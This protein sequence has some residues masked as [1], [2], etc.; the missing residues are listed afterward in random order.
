MRITDEKI[1]EIR[2]A[3]DIVEV[4]S[5]YVRLK[6]QGKSFMGLCPFHTEKTPSFS[7]DP[8]RGFYHCFGCRAGG[9]IF[10]FIMQMEKISFPEAVRLLAK[11][12]GIS[13]PEGEDTEKSLETENLFKANALAMAFFEQCMRGTRAGEKSLSY[14]KSRGFE[15]KTL[16]LFHVGYAPNL[17]DGLIQKAQREAMRLSFL[18][19]AGL[20]I[21]GKTKG[22][23]YDRFRARVMFP[24]FNAAG[25]PVGF[26]GR[27]LGTD[28]KQPKY[29]N[30][31]ETPIF[32]KGRHL[33]GLS[34]AKEGIRREDKIVVVEG[35]TDV[36][37]LHQ[38]GMNHAVASSGTAL[39]DEQAQLMMRYSKNV[40][41]VFDG[42]SAGFQ[43][44][45]RGVDIL[46]KKGA[47][48]SVVPLPGGSDPDTAVL[49]RGAAFLRNAVQSAR[50]FVDFQL[51]RMSVTGHLKTPGQK[52]EAAKMLLDIIH[53]LPDRLEQDLMVKEIAG[54]LGVDEHLL[55]QKLQKGVLE[56]AP[57][58]KEKRP[59][60]RE[61]AE[62][63]LIL[64][65]IENSMAWARHIFRWIS[66]ESIAGPEARAVLEWFVMRSGE[67]VPLNGTDLMN[68]FAGDA[69][70]AAYC[71]RLLATGIDDGVDR[72]KLCRGSIYAL[73]REEVQAEVK[74]M[75]EKMRS[76]RTMGMADARN[77]LDMYSNEYMKLRKSLDILRQ[78][79]DSAFKKSVEN[80]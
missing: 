26:G 2:G 12:A 28:K 47:Q 60:A 48:V 45:L 77:T 1:E 56:R 4:I 14:M 66:P 80:E 74:S 73:K 63:D 70:V 68:H 31:P 17:W 10:N 34:L 39:T 57:A 71:A 6:K 38:S 65:L 61:R 69:R 50:T 7:V 37:R 11:Q 41:L 22:A 79:L 76:V 23:Y 15:T 19:Q 78:E 75:Q 29:I 58:V 59:G 16:D 35:Y 3:S 30:S 25:R 18:A 5:G 42:D 32:Q 52:A 24:I 9:N 64:L 53:S 44:A 51:E 40:V 43:A 49:K 55:I 8:V 33:Y 67:G 36:M 21:P 20:V 13:V 46:V 54:K 62:M 72:E 27:I